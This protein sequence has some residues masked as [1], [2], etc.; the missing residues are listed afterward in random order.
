[1][2]KLLFILA[3]FTSAV[4]FADNPTCPVNTEP[5]KDNLS[6][7]SLP[8]GQSWIVFQKP[9]VFDANV[10][11][12]SLGMGFYLYDKEGALNT[13]RNVI[14]GIPRPLES[15][16]A[17]QGFEFGR[18]RLGT[19]SDSELRSDLYVQNIREWLNNLVEVCIQKPQQEDISYS[20]EDVETL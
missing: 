6:V 10:S 16:T 18:L 5:A 14:P 13:K 1:M 8:I 3:F 9:L 4:A 17:K 2:K 19:V 15:I 11:S 7:Y 20:T 12:I